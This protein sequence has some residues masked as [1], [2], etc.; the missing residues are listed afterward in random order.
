[1]SQHILKN[2]FST[3]LVVLACINTSRVWAKELKWTHYGLRPLGMGNAYVAVAD[4]FNAIFY[5]PAGL[6]RLQ[7]WH[8]ELIN[9]YFAVSK[10]SSDLFKNLSDLQASQTDQ[11]L[12][13][14]DDMTGRAYY[15]G[16]GLTPHLI[17]PGFGVGMGLDTYASLSIHGDISVDVDSRATALVPVAY[18][19]N[20]WGERLSLGAAVKFVGTG[21]IDK[22]FSIADIDSFK[23]SGQQSNSPKLSDFVDAGAGVGLDT[24]L[25]FTPKDQPM[26]PTLGVSITDFGGTPL[27][28]IGA[29]LTPKTRAPS[30]NTGVSLK[31]YK[32]SWSY[33]LTS[34]DVHSINTRDHFSKKLNLGLEYGLGSILK[35]QTGLHQGEMTAGFQLDAWLLVLRFATYSEQIGSSAG[36][37]ELFSERRYILQLKVLI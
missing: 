11:V 33:L 21:G 35:L 8:G 34:L 13:A 6:A 36:A 24:G 2:L 15:A 32:S 10:S 3:G 17:F 27:K 16:A 20:F 18:A 1:M 7:E 19:Q 14:L 22:N 4:D 9:P 37:D 26:E 23:S 30:V 25:L 28:G 29:Y 5:N 12:A 31:P